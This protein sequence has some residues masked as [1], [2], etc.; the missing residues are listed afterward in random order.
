MAKRRG[1]G[2]E[3]ETQKGKS[4]VSERTRSM[5]SRKTNTGGRKEP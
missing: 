2:R 1:E 4:R 3:Q 5:G